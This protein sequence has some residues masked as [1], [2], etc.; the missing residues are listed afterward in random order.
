MT[1]TNPFPKALHAAWCELTTPEA[2]TW[3][4]A[5]RAQAKA[6]ATFT[7]AIA[8]Q[9]IAA[10]QRW[11]KPH[12][13]QGLLFNPDAQAT[14][15]ISVARDANLVFETTELDQEPASWIWASTEANDHETAL[16][17]D[18]AIEDK[19]DFAMAADDELLPDNEIPFSD[20]WECGPPFLSEEEEDTSFFSPED[21]ENTDRLLYEDTESDSSASTADLSAM[22]QYEA[23][24]S[25]VVN[26]EQIAE[27]ELES[28]TA[29][30]DSDLADFEYLSRLLEI[31]PD[32]EVD[33]GEEDVTEPSVVEPIHLVA[34]AYSLE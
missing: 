22:I 10:I 6:T 16:T 5:K 32:S 26:A 30:E 28:E 17:E 8:S 21:D 23:N 11:L 3:Y 27:L 9:G 25:S 31:A 15:S 20:E 33:P 1:T 19:L 14:N 7:Y 12:P 29:E 34:Q 18:E 2:K 4:G 13:K 24:S